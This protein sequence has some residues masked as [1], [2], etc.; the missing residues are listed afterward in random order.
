MRP[1]AAFTSD[2]RPAPL[3]IPARRIPASRLNVMTARRAA[4]TPPHA[5]VKSDV[6]SAVKLVAPPASAF[7]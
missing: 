6:A 4:E 2:P 1:V 5:V 7:A 3:P